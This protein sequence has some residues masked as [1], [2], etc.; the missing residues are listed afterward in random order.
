MFKKV[1]KRGLSSVVITL[2]IVL[3]ALVALGIIWGVIRE[4]ITKYSK[5]VSAFT[6]SLDLKILNAYRSSNQILVNVERRPGPGEIVGLAFALKNGS[7]SE[8]I[9]VD[10]SLGELESKDFTLTPTQLD[11]LTISEVSVAPIYMASGDKTIGNILDT[12][13]INQDYTG[14]LPGNGENGGTTPCVPLS[15]E[16]ACAGYECGSVSDGCSQ[17]YICGTCSDGEVCNLTTHTCQISICEDSRTWEEI[18]GISN[19]GF[20]N[21]LC[22]ESAPCGDLNGLCPTN[23]LCNSSNICEEIIPLNS[24]TVSDTW[25]GT[26][27]MYFGSPDLPQTENAPSMY[28]NKYVKVNNTLESTICR[29]IITYKLPVEGYPYSHIGFNFNTNIQPNDN[30]SIFFTQ[31]QCNSYVF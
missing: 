22:G 11:P 26:S 19:C 24:G 21:N 18:C 12:Y 9:K 31:T 4:V 27:N 7:G 2:I 16:E 17:T 10:T 25:P 30:Y 6:L 15:Q 8:L 3:L 23:Y 28:L 14:S 29:P 13:T 5:P 20:A 1:Q